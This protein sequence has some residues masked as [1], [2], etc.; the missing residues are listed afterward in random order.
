MMLR[1]LVKK[2]K[3]Q[4][5]NDAAVVVNNHDT[6]TQM[7]V[8][9][10]AVDDAATADV[11]RTPNISPKSSTSGSSHSLV[12]LAAAVGGGSDGKEAGRREHFKIII[13][14]F[15]YCRTST[16]FTK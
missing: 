2:L 10:S 1:N 7:T 11:E 12:V 4:S 9:G 14:I 3:N 16:R 6:L 8:G 15:E 5:L 13:K